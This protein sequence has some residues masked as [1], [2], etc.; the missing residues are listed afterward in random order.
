MPLEYLG[1]GN[2]NDV[3]AF[4]ETNES[5]FTRVFKI[6][7]NDLNGSDPLL[8]TPER[9]VRLWN[10]INE[11]SLSK[12]A[13]T[14]EYIPDYK[15]KGKIQK[16]G[17]RVGWTAP[18]VKGRNATPI[19]IEN[20]L[21]DIYNRCGRTVLDAVVAGN[22]KTLDNGQVICVDIGMSLRLQ[23]TNEEGVENA[24]FASLA[25]WDST[26]KDS[27]LPWFQELSQQSRYMPVIETTKALFAL[28]QLYPYYVNVDFLREPQYKTLKK[29]LAQE[30]DQPGSFMK[31]ETAKSLLRGIPPLGN[32]QAISPL[33][34]LPAYKL[35]LKEKLEAYIFSLPVDYQGK[36]SSPLTIKIFKNKTV[37]EKTIRCAEE[38]KNELLETD[39]ISEALE[40]VTD[41]LIHPQ[42]EELLSI[43]NNGLKLCLAEC[44]GGLGQMK[45]QSNTEHLS[46][47]PQ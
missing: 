34:E 32:L 37:I 43:G 28:Q 19:E 14:Q 27:Y 11:G 12:A 16:G 2:F 7:K 6:Q 1:S 35:F 9:S 24:S 8:D 30:I 42:N 38:L 25:A 18:F 36:F 29:A 3:F 33:A 5:S 40:L 47:G 45:V 23:K 13:V 10:Q 22:F 15:V 39:N 41:A 20:T 21:I 31:N 4:R 17:V 46:S 44:S 26:F